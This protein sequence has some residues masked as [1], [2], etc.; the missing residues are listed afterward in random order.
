MKIVILAGGYGTRLAELTSDIPKP[1]VQI[2]EYPILWHIM[3]IYASQGFNE[4]VIALGYKA[5]IIKKFFY[6]YYLGRYRTA[7]LLDKKDAVIMAKAEQYAT[8]RVSLEQYRGV[9][10]VGPLFLDREK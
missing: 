7:A 4:F 3:N 9:A 1:M 2:G 6:E 5:N 10:C 8:E